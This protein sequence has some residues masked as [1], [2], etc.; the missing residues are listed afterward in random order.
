M[1]EQEFREL[2]RA[3]RECFQALT[4]EQ[5]AN[6]PEVIKAQQCVAAAETVHRASAETAHRLRT[7]RAQ[8]E[9][10]GDTCRKHAAELH[11]NRLLQI[12]DALAVTG[13]DV[14]V[15]ADAKL[16]GQVEHLWLVA[17]AVPV[18][19]TNIDLQIKEASR[20]TLSASEDF[21]GATEALRGTLDELK[22]DEARR[23]F[24]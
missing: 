22:L 7:R 3:L 23:G 16:A 8:V 6:H 14:L 24:A 21:L 11:E 19:L 4:D 5:F 17:E 2:P 13:V 20:R 15:D 12:A 9:V 10:L 1:N 18:A